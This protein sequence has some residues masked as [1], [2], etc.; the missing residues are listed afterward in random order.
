MI[1]SVK[2]LLP[3]DFETRGKTSHEILVAA[4]G[5]E[6]ERADERADAYLMA[7]IEGIIERRESV[8]GRNTNTSGAQHERREGGLSAPVSVHSVVSTRKAVELQR[9]EEK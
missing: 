8:A 2:S 6:V 4:A 5:E 7:K 3:K 1:L 9:T